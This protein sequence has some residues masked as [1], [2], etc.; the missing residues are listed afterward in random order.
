MPALLGANLWSIGCAENLLGA[1]VF[2]LA[3]PH[4][5]WNGLVRER[6]YWRGG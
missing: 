6:A 2:S 3:G 5:V 1:A 4:C